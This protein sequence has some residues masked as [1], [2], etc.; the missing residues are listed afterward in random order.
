MLLIGP[1]V[2]ATSVPELV[3]YARK[4]PDA[5][6]FGSAGIGASNHLS[7]E[8]L[9]KQADAPI[10]TCPIAAIRPPWWM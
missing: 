5:V 8:L 4:H 1:Q 3:D 9:K 2:P 10:C 6:S 7:A